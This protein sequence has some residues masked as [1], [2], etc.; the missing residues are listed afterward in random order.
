MAA[1]E[2][3]SIKDLSLEKIFEQDAWD[4][5]QVFLLDRIDK[6][7]RSEPISKSIEQ[8]AEEEIALRKS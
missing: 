2:G 4:E 8:I 6:A 7:K 5:L 1:I 3:K